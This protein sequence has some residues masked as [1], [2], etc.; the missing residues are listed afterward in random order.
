MNALLL[1]DR[2]ALSEPKMIKIFICQ[3]VKIIGANGFEANE[4]RLK[5]HENWNEHQQHKK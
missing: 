3:D 2:M 4:C 5:N 1:H